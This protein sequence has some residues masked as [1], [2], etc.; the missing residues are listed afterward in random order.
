ML[1]V[2]VCIILL[3]NLYMDFTLECEELQLCNLMN[4]LQQ[5]LTG[6]NIIVRVTLFF[7]PPQFALRKSSYS[8]WLPVA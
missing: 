1:V 6:T 3:L 2:I 5:A 8:S 4:L 7:I